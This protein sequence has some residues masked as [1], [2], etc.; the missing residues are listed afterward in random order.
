MLLFENDVDTPHLVSFLT[1]APFIEILEM[2][3]S[4]LMVSSLVICT[5]VHGIASILF[6]VSTRSS[7]SIP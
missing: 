7:I 5:L 1:S 6:Q 4:I 2:D 3:V